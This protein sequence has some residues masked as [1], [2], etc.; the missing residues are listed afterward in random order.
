VKVTHTDVEGLVVFE[1]TPHVDERGFFTRTLDV[2]VLVETGIDPASFKQDNQS[3]SYKGVV[4][5]LHGRIGS[6]EGKLV[7]CAHGAV[8]DAVVDTRVG[9]RTFGEIR[10]FRL[11]DVDHRQIF[12]PRGF[13]H[14]HQALTESADICYR[15]DAFYGPDEDTTVR[16]DD[17]ELAVPWPD[18]VTIVSER[19]R[20]GQTWAEYRRFLGADV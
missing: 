7:R 6:G 8:F 12:I 9:S 19:D 20:I 14:G 13:L 5:G 10:T 4:R 18:P 15:M 16:F 1:P 11:D 17:P 3:R 2:S